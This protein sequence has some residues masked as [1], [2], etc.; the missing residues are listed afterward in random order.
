MGKDSCEKSFPN[1][2]LDRALTNSSRRLRHR[3]GDERF[4]SFLIRRLLQSALDATL[5]N[6][7]ANPLLI[8]LL[9]WAESRPSPRGD[10]QDVALVQGGHHLRPEAD[11]FSLAYYDTFPRLTALPTEQARSVMTVPIG[12]QA[13]VDVIVK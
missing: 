9:R 4:C 13:E 10:G 8:P 1:A 12:V 7:P 3:G 2:I 5:L 6:V 11:L